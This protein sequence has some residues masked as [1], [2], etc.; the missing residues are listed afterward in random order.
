MRL[1][2]K[3]NT[4]VNCNNLEALEKDFFAQGIKTLPEQIESK[5]KCFK[6]LLTLFEEA[7]LSF[8]QVFI[9]YQATLSKNEKLEETFI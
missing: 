4:L 8:F 1:D 7:L 6:E 9:Q 2:T 3:F 5:N